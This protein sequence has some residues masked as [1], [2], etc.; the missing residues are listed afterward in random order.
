MDL[1]NNKIKILIGL[2]LLALVAVGVY[3]LT[4]KYNPHKGAKNIESGII[5]TDLPTGEVPSGFI[6]DLPIEEG[7]QL[8]QNFSASAPDGSTQATQVYT[9]T[10]SPSENLKIF[11]DYM[12]KHG[13]SIGAQEDKPK[14]KML[15][16]VK[17]SLRLQIEIREQEKPLPNTVGFTV[18][19][20][21]K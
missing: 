3:F 10:K 1:F 4:S 20:I 15:F 5:R 9:T 11:S 6:A 12:Q 16:G 13:W 19:T 14:Y 2:V 17:G 21:R 18:N 7:A 8:L